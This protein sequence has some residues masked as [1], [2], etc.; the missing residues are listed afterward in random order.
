VCQ[1]RWFFDG[2]VE[3][4]RTSLH[5]GLSVVAIVVLTFLVLLIP[6]TFFFT[7]FASM[8]KEVKDISYSGLLKTDTHLG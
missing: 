1:Q 5:V 6:A 7:I 4:F 3:C 8:R 2:E